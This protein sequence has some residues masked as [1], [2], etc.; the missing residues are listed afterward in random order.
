MIHSNHA[1]LMSWRRDVAHQA[2]KEMAHL[3]AVHHAVWP[4]AGPVGLVVT[5]NFER[6]A[7][8]HVNR[9]LTNPLRAVAPREHYVKPDVDK[10]VRA[11][12]DALTDCGAI[13]DDSQI[14]VLRATKRWTTEPAHATVQLET[15]TK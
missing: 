3:S 4:A 12:G 8:H 2:M 13:V 1:N 6:P 5:F 14:T 15:Y 7:A 9:K 10:L 11:I